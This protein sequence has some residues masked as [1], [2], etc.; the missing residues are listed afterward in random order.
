MKQKIQ[1]IVTISA[2]TILTLSAAAQNATIETIDRP[3]RTGKRMTMPVSDRL[4]GAAK[5]SDLVGMNVNNYQ[6]EKL[7]KVEDIAVDLESGRIVQV[8]ISTGGFLG[9]GDVLSAVPPGALHHDMANKVL[10]LDASKE[11]LKSAPQF[12]MSKWSESSDSNHLAQVYGHYGQEKSFLFVGSDDAS[13]RIPSGERANGGHRPADRALNTGEA[14][15]STTGGALNETWERER[16]LS[17]RQSM[18]P[19]SRL[20]RVQKVSALMGTPIKNLQDEKLGKVENILI[21]IA[22]GRV[23]AIVVSSGGFLGMGNELSALPPTALRFTDDQRN[24]QIDSTK[25]AMTAAPHFKADQWPDFAQP[26][27]ANGIYRAYNV[28]PY[29]TT[30]LTSDADNTVRNVRDRNNST[31]TPLDQGNSKGDIA[32]TAQIRKQIIADKG[33]SVNAR[34]VKIITQ[35]GRVTLRGP[36]NTAEEKQKIGEIAN[37]IAQAANVDNQ[38]EVRGSTTNNN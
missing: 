11:K 26:E 7:G 28:Q 19:A 10:H 20:G 17:D 4:N 34:N 22:S 2:A 12:E 24:L 36:V 23:L 5:C 33:M 18:I 3:E 8:I 31:L 27:Y 9:V 21:D 38:L 1:S 6:G 15:R 30:N 14:G 35:D 13:D 37:Q 25:E 32:T 16:A 29:F